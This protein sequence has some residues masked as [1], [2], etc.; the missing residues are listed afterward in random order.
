[1]RQSETRQADCSG[2]KNKAP[3][4]K[5]FPSTSKVHFIFIPCR[6]L[7]VAH[8]RGID[9]VCQPMMST[10]YSTRISK[11]WKSPCGRRLQCGQH[12]FFTHVS[13]NYFPSDR[14][15]RFLKNDAPPTERRGQARRRRRRRSTASMIH[16]GLSRI[17]I[18]ISVAATQTYRPGL[19][20]C[21]E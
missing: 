21:V 20:K 7:E 3:P 4:M 17:D 14:H 6:P 2:P 15:G 8:L 11:V 9:A 10:C 12:F 5:K 18:D 19:G 16:P 1:M 13:L